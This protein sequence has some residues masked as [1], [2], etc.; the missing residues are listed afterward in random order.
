M[1]DAEQLGSGRTVPCQNSLCRCS[2]SIMAAALMVIVMAGVSTVAIAGD[3][4]TAEVFFEEV[5]SNYSE[6]EDY[7]AQVVIALSRFEPAT[8]EPDEESES[9]DNDDPESVAEKSVSTPVL[10]EIEL[11][12]MTGMISFKRPDQLRIDFIQPA[13]GVMVSDGNYLKI[14]LPEF[15]LIIEQ[16]LE[17]QDPAANTALADDLAPILGL[18]FLRNNYAIA[19]EVGPNPV[20]IGDGSGREV[21][22]LVLERQVPEEGFE[23]IIVAVGEDKLIRT[24]VGEY[25]SG[26]RW[27]IRFRSVR[28]NQSIPDARFQF[29]SPPDANIYH[30]V[31]SGLID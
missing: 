12:R 5:A 27:S 7:Q 21:V 15:N 14:Y 6:I 26:D 18:G 29:E 1:R 8:T 31:L 22:R 3:L 16:L 24:I 13:G 2:A 20:P 19:Y 11:S 25:R 9:I 17:D 30:D 10:E 4:V 28:I 23:T